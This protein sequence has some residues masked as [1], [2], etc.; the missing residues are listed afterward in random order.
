MKKCCIALLAVLLPV[1]FGG[2]VNYQSRP[3]DLSTQAQAL[4]TRRLDDSGLARYAA[5]LGH[6]HWPPSHWTRADLLI[7]ALYYNPAI[8]EARDG[9]L[10]A[11]AGEITAREY[12]NPKLT[13]SAEYALDGGIPPWLYGFLLNALLPQTDLRHAQQLQ[14]HFYTQA[15]GWK[16]AQTLWTVRSRVRSALLS[17]VYAHAAE[18]ALTRQAGDASQLVALLSAQVQAGEASAPQL[19]TAQAQALQARQ[20]RDDTR[21]RLSTARHALA[22]AIG[23]PATE[24]PDLRTIW[25]DWQSPA[26]IPD[27]RIERLARRALLTRAD[28]ARAVADYDAAQ[29]ALRIEVDQQSPSV[30]IAPGYTW[31]HGVHKLPLSVSFSLP[32]F[33]QNQGPIA[34]AMARRAQAGAHLQ[35]VQAQ[36][37]AEIADARTALQE[38]AAIAQTAQHHQLPLAEQQ[39]HAAQQRFA[40]GDVD[41]A[42]LLAAR[43]NAEDTHLAT[44]RAA[45]QAQTAR[46]ALED[47]L[48]HPF[49]RNEINLG[50]ARL[51]PPKSDAPS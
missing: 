37:L 2:C 26:A 31:D 14:A 43:I 18:R 42:A 21:A 5:R 17:A 9:L 28:L 32:I 44:L 12:P 51:R 46:G 29:Q 41:H 36:I 27:G 19:Q 4:Q 16:L 33:N 38:R 30:S 3:I 45:F 1:L 24:L 49:N 39:L 13:L 22:A 34:Q 20:S 10:A 15:A 40:I 35:T 6:S 23:I 11:R 47:A 7:A 48:H 50:Q 25:P 8:V